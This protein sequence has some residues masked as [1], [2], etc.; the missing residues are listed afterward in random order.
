M[1]K[2]GDSYKV[3]LRLAHLGWGTYRKTNTRVKR[4]GEAYIQIPIKY[5][6]KFNI[7]NSNGTN[8]EDI[9][10]V[11]LFYCASADGLFKGELRAQGAVKANSIFAKQFSV[12][13][14]LKAVGKWYE[15]LG[16][17]EGDII[18]VSWETD[19]NI[20]IEKL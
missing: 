5:A 3:K 14:D 17:H 16:A 18:K 12:N 13:K 1:A 2:A 7:L 20:I 4:K 8:G 6:R 19:A 11:N 15:Q 9:Y 10:G